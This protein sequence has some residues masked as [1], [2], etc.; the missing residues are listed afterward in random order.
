MV[1]GSRCRSV[2]ER[3]LYRRG[4][5]QVLEASVSILAID[6]EVQRWMRSGGVS[7]YR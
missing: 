2:S 4:S 6:A 3:P 7:L 5:T 1:V